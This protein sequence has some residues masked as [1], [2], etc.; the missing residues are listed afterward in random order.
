MSD[1]VRPNFLTCPAVPELPAP[2]ESLHTQDTNTESIAPVVDTGVLVDQIEQ[3]TVAEP[4]DIFEES[5]T[6]PMLP[7][8]SPVL[9]PHPLRPLV[10]VLSG[11]IIGVAVLVFTTIV[12]GAIYLGGAVSNMKSAALAMRQDVDRHDFVAA[13]E[14]LPT[15][16]QSLDRLSSGIQKLHPLREWPV[17][18]RDI[19]TL[20]HLMEIAHTLSDGVDQTVRAASGFEQVLESVG[21]LER[22]LDGSVV[23]GRP[24]ASLSPSEKEEILS[25]FASLLPELRQAREKVKLAA[26]LWGD[27]PAE[28]RQSSMLGPIAGYGDRLPELTQRAD[29]LIAFLD[30]L[31]PL[32]GHPSENRYLVVLQNS[33]EL[34]ATGGFLGTIGY[35]R[36]KS[37]DVKEMRFDDVYT[38][39]N[40]VSQTWKDVPPAPLTQHLGVPAWFLR[41]RNWSPD[42]P[43]SAEDMMKTYLGER[44]LASTGTTDYLD[45]V[46]AFTPEFFEDLLRFTGPISVNGKEFNAENFFDQLQYDTEQ[47]FLNQGISV[48]Q[49][50]DIVLKLGDELFKKLMQQSTDRLPVLLDLLTDNLARKNVLFYLRDP[51]TRSLLDARGWTGRASGTPTDYLWVIDSN[52]GALKTDGKM[53]KE[54]RYGVDLATGIATVTLHYRN[55]VRT[56][57]WRYS[58]YRDYVRVYVP[59]GSELLSADGAMAR[60]KNQAGGRVEPGKV[61]VFKDLGKTVFGAFWALEPGETRDLRFSYRLPPTVLEAM[62]ATNSYELLV[63]RQP[64]NQSRLTLDHALG[65]NVRA[66]EPSEAPAQFGDQRYQVTTPLDRDRTF[67]VRF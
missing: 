36:V 34:R 8:A 7:P 24:F 45:G 42:F 22:G 6:S 3:P 55:T 26:S 53:E 2:E 39:D 14:E 51:R 52:L 15:F 38:I 46:I 59:E 33:D 61:D 32:V 16:L 49:R 4:R 62:R 58:R 37:A 66:A 27:L 60:D 54:T 57:D 20:E 48:D 43:T 63:Q 47:G 30:I 9:T 28:A 44:A 10:L 56:I 64:G 50:K 21:L 1:E 19:R 35:V 29:Q 65:K 67:R 18:G 17:L 31:L 13:E 40:P 12:V 41:D 25:R 11:L 5:P 23:S